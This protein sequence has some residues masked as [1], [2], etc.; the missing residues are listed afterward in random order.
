MART[1]GVPRFVNLAG[2]LFTLIGSAPGLAAAAEPDTKATTFTKDVAPIFQRNCQVCHHPGTAAPMSLMTYADVRPWARSIKQRV[3]L[4]EMPPW[5]IDRTQGI[6]HY[7]NDRSLSDAE[8]AT[9]V[10]WVDGGA[11]AGDPK[12]LP[13]PLQ[14]RNEDE[15]TIGKPDLIVTSP[16][17]VVS[18]SGVDWWGDY[19]VPT[20][21]TEDRYVK[22]IETKPSKDGRFVNHHAVVSVIQDADP[23]ISGRAAGESGKVT[24]SFSEYVVGKYGDVFSDGSGRLLKA[25]SVLRFGMH[26][27]SIG[28]EHSDQTSVGIVFYPK[29]YVPKYISRW[30][31]LFPE[32]FNDL[33]IPPGQVT[34]ADG[35]YRLPKSARIDA[36]QPHM[37]MRGKAQCLEAI[38]PNTV[39]HPDS[40]PVNARSGATKRE[41]LGCVDRFDFN[42]QVAYTFADDAAPLLPAGT[43]LHQISIFDNTA[44]NRHNPDPTV[45]VGYG[46]RSVD[47]MDNTHVT[48]V[49]LSDEDFNRQLA[50]RKAKSAQKLTSA[51]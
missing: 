31:T 5:H 15:W 9:I 19:D 35:Y 29:G 10:G 50:E 46:Q 33:E 13:A 38:Y 25:G 32:D 7:K 43:I 1:I 28:E 40:L 20:G 37:H 14:F 41:I 6:Q 17:H 45:W 8:I 16:K 34:R 3:S 12:D 21:L 30:I 22:A 48:A 36:F 51:R 39:E 11:P 47:E 24:S 2:L 4:R 26:Y 44:A 18:A 23:F 27:H 49:F 42:W